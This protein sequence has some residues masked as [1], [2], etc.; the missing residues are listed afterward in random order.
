MDPRRIVI[1]LVVVFGLSGCVT[2]ENYNAQV[3]RTNN[4]QRLLSEEEKRTV[5][6]S[7]EIARLKDQGAILEGKHKA[8]TAQFNDSKA[9][10]V[11]SLEEVGR[12]QDEVKQARGGFSSVPAL[13]GP[14]QEPPDRLGELQ[15]K[16]AAP[17]EKKGDK[18]KGKAEAKVKVQKPSDAPPPA[19]QPKV[20]PPATVPSTPF[21]PL[22]R[23]PSQE[24]PDR[25][26]ELQAAPTVK[27]EK[28]VEKQ[29]EKPVARQK[30][31][32]TAKIR[33][34]KQSEEPSSPPP[35]VEAPASPP[36][37]PAK[38]E[39]KA[40]VQAK[41]ETKTQAKPETEAAPDDSF[42]RY[43]KVKKGETLA[44][45]AKQYRTDAQTLRELND[46]ASG[47]A[48]RPGDRLI[49]GQKQ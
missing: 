26:G 20:A 17:S 8:L 7:T 6:L 4:F 45:I 23:E 24:P 32:A 37:P 43:H 30:G 21:E 40:K 44:G 34:Q 14:S 47:D 46:L 11:R 49:V 5:E 41:T 18:K 12:L 35:Q 2:K 27:S 3:L 19:P 36:P 38:A 15:E 25:L 1:V 39:A 29:V 31:K 42:F 9:Q 10:V 48:V 22:L 33:V 16:P 28:K 13:R